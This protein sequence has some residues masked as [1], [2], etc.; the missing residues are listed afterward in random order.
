[1][2]CQKCG[3]KNLEDAKFCMHCGADL[4]GYKVESSPKISVSAKAEG[5][6]ALKWK[7]K[8][9]KYAEIKGIGKLPVYHD[10]VEL[11]DKPFCP[12]C[13]NYGSLKWE[14]EKRD[15]MRYRS[16][17]DFIYIGWPATIYVVY[18]VLKHGNGWAWNHYHLFKCH[19]CGSLS[20]LKAYAD[21][22]SVTDFHVQILENV[23]LDLKDDGKT[24]IYSW[25]SEVYRETK[26]CSP[27]N[28][29]C[30]MCG[31]DSKQVVSS[32][33]RKK[34]V[35]FGVCLTNYIAYDL[36]KCQ[37][38]GFQFLTEKEYT[39]KKPTSCK[40]HIYPLCEV[41]ENGKAE[42]LLFLW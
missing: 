5:G 38:C 26:Y 30:P 1:M 20:L 33:F 29:T 19:A 6:V 39:S 21:D 28:P 4:S 12:H 41:C 8:P 32:L 14:K 10:F 3:E 25:I 17:N 22:P 40:V 15:C 35:K 27:A 34:M 36:W 2:Y 37:A 24:P 9:I 13:G 7:Q 18:E 11:E 16:E 42:L 23:Y 31:T